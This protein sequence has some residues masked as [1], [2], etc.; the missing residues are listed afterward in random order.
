MS[1]KGKVRFTI[2]AS[3]R[4]NGCECI[5]LFLLVFLHDRH[6]QPIQ[7]LV[8]PITGGGTT[9]LDIPLPVM[10]AV[11][12][13]TLCHLG[14]THSVG[15]ILLVREDQKDGVTELILTKH[16]VELVTSCIRTLTII[17]IHHKDDAMGILIVV[18]PQRSDLVLPSDIPHSEANILVL[19]GFHVESNG[20][21]SSH[22][23][24][25]LE[26][27]QNSRLQNA[28][29]GSVQKVHL[30]SVRRFLFK[31]GTISIKKSLRWVI[32]M[33]SVY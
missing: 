24:A 25:K 26:L 4:P 18:S 33:T 21:D 7:A 10:K 23:L 11:K 5:K 13:E 22:H 32:I 19:H 12:P 20:G 16:A 29:T 14:G 31:Q 1:A 3:D 28:G 9:S 15:Q 8:K 27:V 17:G 30:V 2:Q 6:R